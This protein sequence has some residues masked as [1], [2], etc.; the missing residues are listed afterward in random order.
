MEDELEALINDYKNLPYPT[1]AAIG[2]YITST[3]LV[4]QYIG[5]VVGTADIR[6]NGLKVVVDCANGAAFMVAPEVFRQLGAEVVVLSDRPDGVNINDNCGSTHL[7]A[8]QAA[9]LQHSAHIGIANDGDADRCLAVDETGS[10]INGDRI[11]LIIGLSLMR[12]GKLKDNTIVATVMS[13]LGMKKAFQS[14]GGKLE[15]TPVGDR[16]VLEKMLEKGYTIGGEQSGHVIFTNHST[17]GDGVL[18]ALQLLCTLK[19]SGK[20]MSELA[21]TM[22]EYPQILKNLRVKSRTGWQ[23]NAAI[24]AAITAVEKELGDDGRVLVR[25]SGTEPLIRVMAEGPDEKRLEE[26][27]DSI[28]NVIESEQV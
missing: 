5:Y 9:V 26:M 23:D 6:L 13:N 22:I 17:T 7:E 10:V 8:L 21:A 16:Y 19:K 4:E 2:E 12:E 28:V 15:I 20:L 27:I 24:A 14:A 11:M 3:S 18:S 25:A 1:G